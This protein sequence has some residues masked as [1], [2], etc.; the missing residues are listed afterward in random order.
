MKTLHG[1][2]LVGI[3]MV[4][5]ASYSGSAEENI[6]EAEGRQ[7]AQ[8]SPLGDV[9]KLVEAGLGAD[10]LLAWVE[11]LKQLDELN[12]QEIVS[13]K[14][15]KVPEKV[16]A[17]LI[18]RAGRLNEASAPRRS[19][20]DIQVVRNYEVPRITRDNSTSRSPSESIGDTDYRRVETSKPYTRQE[21]VTYVFRNPSPSTVLYDSSLVS[22]SYINAYP[23]TYSYPGYTYCSDYTRYSYPRLSFGLYFGNYGR[24]YHHRN[25]GY[26]YNNYRHHGSYHYGHHNSYRGHG[27]YKGHRGGARF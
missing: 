14:E 19:S 25:Y 21:A 5:G 7:E 1:A 11:S 12:S 8:G 15:K 23:V 2:V 26:R 13:L 4:C 17:A 16:I 18:R 22:R 27:S 6:S 24:Y 3:L 9:V 20:D 10:V